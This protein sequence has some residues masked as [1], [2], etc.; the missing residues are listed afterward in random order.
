MWGEHW[1]GGIETTF[2]SWSAIA[3][4]NGLPRQLSD[5]EF[6]ALDLP[7]SFALDDDED[8]YEDDEDDILSQLGL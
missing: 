3:N 7:S 6:E 5:V 4:A 8:D 2:A 1:V